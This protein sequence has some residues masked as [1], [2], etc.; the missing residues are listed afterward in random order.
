MTTRM[1]RPT[2]LAAALMVALGTALPAQSQ[3]QSDPVIERIY[4]M[5]MED[6]H[7]ESLA[8]SLLDSIG[9]RLTGTPQFDG[10]N[11]WAV[12]MLRSWGVDARMDQYGTWRGWEQGLLHVDLL[13]PRRQTLEAHLLAWSPGT[14]G[15]VAGPVTVIPEWQTE[16]EYRNW[17][18]NEVPGKFVA[19]SF[20]EP[21]CRP[22]D[23]FD[24][25]GSEGAR[26]RQTELRSQLLDRYRENRTTGA[27]TGRQDLENAGAL[28]ILELSWRGRTGINTV[29]GT[30]TELVPTISLSCEDYGRVWRLAENGSG[31][32]LRVNAEA[33]DLG[34]VPAYNTIGIMRGTELP[35]EYI[36]LSAHYDSW[37]SG[38]GATDNG[39]GSLT[40]LEAMRILSEVY[41]NP[42]RTIMIG[43]WGGEEHGLIGSRRFV[44]ENGEIV[45][46]MQA[47]FNQDNGTGRIQNIGM[48]GLVNA[49]LHWNRWLEAIPSSIS[50]R[51]NISS[52]G[53]PSSGGTDHA[54]FICAGAPAFGLS[55][56]SWGYNPYTWH[57][58]RDTYDK[59]VFEEV[60]H[61]ATLI[62]MLAYL[63]SEDPERI[64][65]TRREGN[66]PNCSPGRTSSGR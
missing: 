48:Q 39:T 30:N 41:P 29:F 55:S 49:H 23:H 35:D 36:I 8:H 17:L 15:P 59:I 46:N 9:A 61:N 13:E 32:F 44:F 7:L 4:Q 20:P 25:W 34:E 40:M 21:S 42:K 27:A 57:T 50:D 6:S 18:E 56:V 58:N 54:S 38:D 26:E 63:A 43:L 2:L 45:D 16:A 1:F 65:R 3:S 51:L 24:Q 37:Q 14:E 33:R 62:A 12:G 60:R 19:V 52:P 31:P 11:A 66:W 22:I 28:G 47:L 64:D 10:A 5:G 53:N